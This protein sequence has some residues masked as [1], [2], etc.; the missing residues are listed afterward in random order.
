M[1]KR[2][3]YWSLYIIKDCYVPKVNSNDSLHFEGE[4][5]YSKALSV[6]KNMANNNSPGCDGFTVEFFKKNLNYS[7]SF[8]YLF[9]NHGYENGKLSCTKN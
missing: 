2:G 8:Y 3:Q 6:L 9:I 5:W 1:L 7:R 4:K